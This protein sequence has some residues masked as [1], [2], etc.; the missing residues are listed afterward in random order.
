MH[1]KRMRNFWLIAMTLGLA[2]AMAL[3]A[4]GAAP[5]EREIFRPQ[6]Y[7]FVAVRDTARIAQGFK[8]SPTGEAWRDPAMAPLK[9]ALAKASSDMKAAI[10]ASMTERQTKDAAGMLERLRFALATLGDVRDFAFALYID[11]FGPGFDK[12]AGSA[13]AP[14]TR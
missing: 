7:F 3:P 2:L 1:A 10:G 6:P 9:Q 11:D 4:L 8:A 13:S 14:P 12:S 5:P